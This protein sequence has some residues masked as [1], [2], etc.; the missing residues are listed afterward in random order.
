MFS[1][2]K[3]VQAVINKCRRK[4]PEPP[5]S[6]ACFL[7]AISTHPIPDLKDIKSR[8]AEI[9][10][11]RKETLSIVWNEHARLAHLRDI[12]PLYVPD[13]DFPVELPGAWRIPLLPA[14]RWWWQSLAAQDRILFYAHFERPL[15]LIW[16]RGAR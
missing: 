2:S 15:P 7:L 1:L 4:A 11:A 10:A 12:F 14:A 6:L 8:E 13:I 3:L 5:R 9:W 16:E